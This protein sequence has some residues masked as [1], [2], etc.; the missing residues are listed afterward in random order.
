[1]KAIFSGMAQPSD[2][3]LIDRCLRGQR[4]AYGVLVE[5]YQNL[6][7]SLAYSACGSFTRSEDLAQETFVTAWKE[8]QRLREREKF[9]SWLCGIA[10]NVINNALRRGTRDATLHA[11]PLDAVPESAAATAAPTEHIIT[12]EE[13]TLVWN[14]LEQIPETYREPL[15]LFYR[16]GQSVHSVAQE[17]EL[18][19][20]AV[21][22]RLSRGRQMLK[23]Q[24]ASLVETTL[25]SSVPKKAFAIAVLASL[26]ALAPSAAAATVAASAKGAGAVKSVAAL[27]WVGAIMGPL[28]GLLGGYLGARASIE[29]T[30]SPRERQF[31][32]RMSWLT[33]GLVFGF[34]ALM[35]G[36][37]F[38]ARSW[39]RAHPGVF[40][41]LIIGSVVGYGV[42]LFDLII[43]SNR[44][45][46]EIQMEDGTH[47]TQQPAPQNALRAGSWSYEYRSRIELLGLPLVHVLFGPAPAGYLTLP[48]A[49]GWI[50]VGARA[51]GL[52]AVGSMA[53]GGIAIGGVAVGGIAFSGLAVGL[54]AIGGLS[55]GAWSIGG[56]AIGLLAFGG[57]AFAWQ[58]ALGGVAMAHDMAVGGVVMGAHAN[59][60]LAR[61]FVE[62]HAFFRLARGLIPFFQWLWLLGLIPCIGAGWAMA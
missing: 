58:A 59:D 39:M 14:A 27:S 40:A 55:L 34:M 5:R 21:K 49:K 36:A 37:M 35:F 43:W 60:A 28:I 22:Q 44:R 10:R 41:T 52:I 42:A 12:Q 15:V 31:M 3:E 24:V 26:P 54:L 50:A 32:V 48:V 18:S 33:V 23:E 8:L 11:A 29:N 46:R 45:Q 30:K 38:F 13:E 6:V 1:M 25:S 61:N 16:E 56:C 17:L 62:Q 19:E 20:D 57:G 4:E 9:K 47:W 7:C 53:L 2:S 51:C